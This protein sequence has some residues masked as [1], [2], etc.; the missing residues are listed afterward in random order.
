MNII[1]K[2]DF[3]IWANEIARISSET[4]T[5]LDVIR[6]PI[7]PSRSGCILLKS[8]PEIKLLR[9]AWKFR[10]KVECSCFPI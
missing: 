9:K 5:S 1:L 8:Y 2:L 10:R 3:D 7:I 4:T 6:L